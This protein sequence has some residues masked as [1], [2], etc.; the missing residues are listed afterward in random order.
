VVNC[1]ERRRIGQEVLKG[2]SEERTQVQGEKVQQMSPLRPFPG[3]YEEIWALQN[4]LPGVGPARGNP[5]R[6]QGKLVKG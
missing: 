5:W 1:Y 4:M 3:L 6:G 2:K